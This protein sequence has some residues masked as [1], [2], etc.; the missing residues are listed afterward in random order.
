MKNNR[1]FTLIEII[2]VI[3]ILGILSLISFAFMGRTASTYQMATSQGKMNGELWVAMERI[4]RE[5]QYTGL[6]A[7]IT[8]PALGGTGTTLT[9]T[10]PACTI[11]QDTATSVTYTLS[12][13]QILRTTATLANQVLADGITA[14]T[15]TRTATPQNVVTITI[16]K[17]DGSESLTLTE[18]VYPWVTQ[19]GTATMTENIQ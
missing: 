9:F 11:C 2:M 12:G 1:G 3:S 7:N 18:S 5:L 4:V 6:P 10:K 14:F 15:V 17:T 16:T 13:T 8:A 19:A